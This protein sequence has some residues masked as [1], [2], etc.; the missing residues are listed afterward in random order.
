MSGL[1]AKL[2]D[3]ITAFA[4][5]YGLFLSLGEVGPGNNLSLLASKSGLTAV[6]GQY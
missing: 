5:V 4:V 6:R 1:Y 3:R 2:T